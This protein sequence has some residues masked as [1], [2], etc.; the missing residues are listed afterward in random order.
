MSSLVLHGVTHRYPGGAGPVLQD[1]D[2]NLS[3]ALESRGSGF[4]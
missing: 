3:N 4:E 2:L 1:L